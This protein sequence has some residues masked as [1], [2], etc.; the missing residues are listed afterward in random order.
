M[1][2]LSPDPQELIAVISELRSVVISPMSPYKPPADSTCLSASS[3]SATQAT[4]DEIA[5]LEG[6]RNANG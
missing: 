5:T 1:S 4:H 3:V 6:N 2:G